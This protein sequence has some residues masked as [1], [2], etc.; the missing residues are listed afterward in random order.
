MS[1]ASK[2]PETSERKWKQIGSRPIRHDG[3]DKVTG[4]ACFGADFALPG[5]LRGVFVRSPHAHARILSID[6]SKAEKVPGVRAIITADDFADVPMGWIPA[7]STGLDFGAN[8]RTILARE[9]VLFHGHAFA[10]VAATTVEIAREAGS[11][12]EVEYEVLEPVLSLEE[13]LAPGASILHEGQETMGDGE[14]PEG[15]SNIAHQVLFEGGD[16]EAGFAEA[17]VVVEGHFET[18]MVH[19]GYIEPHACVANVRE[20][21]TSEIWCATQGAFG[22]KSEVAMITGTDPNTIKV[23]PSEI[24]GGFGGKIAVYLEPAALAL[25]RKAGRP[26]KMTMTREEVFRGTGPTSGSRSWGRIGAKADGTLVAAEARM[27]FEAG[28]FRGSPVG[29]ACMTIFTPYEIPNF[30]VFGLDVVLNKPRVGAYRAPG[31]PVG[32]FIAE[33]LFDELARKLDRDPIGLRLQN[34]IEE[35]GR[36]KYGPAFGPI[37]FK[38]TLEAAR[39]HPHYKAPLGPNQGRGVAAGFWFNAGMQSSATVSVNDDGSA[40][41]RT[42]NPDIGGSRASMALMV[43]E[44]LGIDV[45]RVRPVVGDTDTVG[46]CDVT[47]GSRVTYATGMAAI[48]ASRQVIDC[49]RTRAAMIWDVEIDSVEW[50]DG[51]AV[52]TNGAAEKGSLS[53]AEIAQQ[54]RLTGGPIVASA[55]VNP[56]AAGPAFG[57]HLCDVEVD[58]ETGVTRVLRYTVAQD[59]GKAIHPT[60]VEGQFQGGAVQ[61]IG[62]ALNEEYLWD[63]DGKVENPGFIDYRMPVAS[64]LPMIDTVIVEVPEPLHPYGVRGVG[65]TPIVPPLGT[66]ANAMRDATGVRFHVLPMSPPRVLEALEASEN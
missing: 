62:W 63:A 19:Q 36:A 65:E 18:P 40:V 29:A 45:I 47:G 58:P 28:A 6:T 32:A 13:A 23:T 30:K 12:I 43:A 14:K 57:V 49:L 26:V 4:R 56:P 20:D 37:G 1:R 53:L 55:S 15:D 48:D 24:G 61:G 25:S 51:N 38:Q 8:A 39:D 21:G 52:A 27:E 5:M 64:D 16:F 31:A 50:R 2:N 17:D 11:L 22:V 46:Y 7:G 66:V 3:L 59:A 33:S 34:A 35:G 10:A 44:E 54:M 60:F 9:K 41:V 42:G